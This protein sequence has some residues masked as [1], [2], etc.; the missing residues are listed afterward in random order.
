MVTT[1]KRIDQD[2]RSSTKGKSPFTTSRNDSERRH[3][4]KQPKSVPCPLRS[5]TL[6]RI[7]KTT[8][9]ESYV[10]RGHPIDSRSSHKTQPCQI[11]TKKV[12]NGSFPEERKGVDLSHNIHRLPKR[13]VY[14]NYFCRPLCRFRTM[15]PTIISPAPSKNS[16]IHKSLVIPRGDR[17]PLI[18]PAPNSPSARRIDRPLAD[19]MDDNAYNPLRR[20]FHPSAPPF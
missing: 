12:P 19:V 2:S 9:W 20:K 1:D 3:G 5:L 10:F 15:R 4:K 8:V 16:H 17:R 6:R 7:C 11:S 14:Q 13:N 18:L